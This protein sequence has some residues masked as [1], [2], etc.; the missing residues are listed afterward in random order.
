MTHK[1]TIG[2]HIAKQIT[3]GMSGGIKM[4]SISRVRPH[5]LGHYHSRED[6]AEKPG[7][8][9]GKGA[10]SIQL[11]RRSKNTGP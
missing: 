7:H 9:F 2:N 5:G 11:R 10:K 4:I 6:A 8:W 1:A 3:R